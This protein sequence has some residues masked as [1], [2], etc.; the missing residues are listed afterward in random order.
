M[1]AAEGLGTVCTAVRHLEDRGLTQH[2]DHHHSSQPRA[3]V[4]PQLP[5]P[6]GG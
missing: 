3:Q 1:L 5:G 2:Q 6:L 4:S